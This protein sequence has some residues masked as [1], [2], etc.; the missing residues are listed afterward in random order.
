MPVM[1]TVAMVMATTTTTTMVMMARNVMMVGGGV[2][3]LYTYGCD[4]D[5]DRDDGDNAREAVM[6]A[7]KE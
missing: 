7:P 4:W 6:V 1:A 2:G 5:S 3:H